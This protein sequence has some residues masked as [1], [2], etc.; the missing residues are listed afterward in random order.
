M[1]SSL[2]ILYKWKEYSVEN[3]ISSVPFLQVVFYFVL[4][5]FLKTAIIYH[6]KAG[7]GR[8]DDFAFQALDCVP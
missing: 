2:K 7:E 8:K 5:S 3:N 1:Q 6:G 4:L